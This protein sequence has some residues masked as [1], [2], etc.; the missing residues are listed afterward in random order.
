MN[1]LRKYWPWLL[2]A[3]VVLVLYARSKATTRTTPLVGDG[4]WVADVGGQQT[5][6]PNYSGL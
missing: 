1:F 6:L 4:A 2:V 5:I 3:G